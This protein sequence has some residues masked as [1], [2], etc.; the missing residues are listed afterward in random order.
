MNWTQVGANIA[1]ILGSLSVI[2]ALVV[3]GAERWQRSKKRRH[4]TRLRNW[5]GSIDI[6]GIDTWYVRLPEMPSEPTA[7][8]VLEVLDADDGSPTV[9]GGSRMRKRIIADRRQSRSPTTG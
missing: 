7:R 5:H 2:T 4:E 6:G 8:V 3:W 1:T 9:T